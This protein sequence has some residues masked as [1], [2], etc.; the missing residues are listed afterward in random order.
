MFVIRSM[1]AF[2]RH[3]LKHPLGTL[4]CEL[5]TVNHRYLDM[6]LRL[7]DEIRAVE[8]RLREIATSSL[9]RGK[10]EC[11]MR[12]QPPA[13]DADSLQLDE[14][15]LDAVMSACNRIEARMN[16]AASSSAMDLLRWPGVVRA[17]DADFAP[18]QEAACALFSEA[19][20][21][22]QMHRKAEGERLKQMLLSRHAAMAELVA[23]L[24]VGAPAALR[25]L[26]EKL[27]TRITNLGVQPEEGRLEQELAY[28]AQRLDVSEELDRLDSHLTS[29]HDA[30]ESDEPVGRKLD[31]L[32]QEFNREA[33]TLGSK[34]ADI[35][36]T[37]T[38][39]E[40]KVLIEQMREQIQNIE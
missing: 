6:S 14:R 24:H 23:K 30:L 12:Y 40:I 39:V 31:F 32:M 2:A 21:S 4:A 10:L 8:G 9:R 37:Q 1:T 34:S 3:E 7:P 16:N 33:N 15:M 25:T 29:L 19:L 22:L 17:T 27:T 26:R 36:T 20:K 38:A 13:G 18:L 5:K 28:V 35:E 11:V